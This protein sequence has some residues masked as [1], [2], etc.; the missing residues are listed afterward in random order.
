MKKRNCFVFFLVVA[1][2]T[3]FVPMLQAQDVAKININ[4]ATVDELQ[5][6]S[7]IG[8]SIADR[9]VKYREEHGPFK[10][11]EDIQSVK[12]IGAKKFEAIKERIT[13]E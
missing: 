9:I 5:Q 13:V 4:M 12:G 7:G 3:A 1:L 2:L 10:S 8:K 11:A 6:I